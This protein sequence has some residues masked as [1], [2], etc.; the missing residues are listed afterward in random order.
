MSLKSK[1]SGIIHYF[2]AFDHALRNNTYPC[3]EKMSELFPY[4]TH[5][6]NITSTMSISWFLAPYMAHRKCI[7]ILIIKHKLSLQGVYDDL[8]SCVGPTRPKSNT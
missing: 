1:C 6:E 7:Y 5:M 2:L 8:R 3:F 4:P